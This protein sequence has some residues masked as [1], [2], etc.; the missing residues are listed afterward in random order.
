[1]REMREQESN[2]RPKRPAGAAPRG[3]RSEF[4]TAL[5]VAREMPSWSSCSSRR[6]SASL[7]RS[8]L[9]IPRFF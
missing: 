7:E 1:M 2:R 4:E 8:A 3:Q 6:A 9:G 5:I